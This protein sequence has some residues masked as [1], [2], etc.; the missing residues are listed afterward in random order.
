MLPE[1]KRSEVV[2][3]FPAILSCDRSLEYRVTPTSIPAPA[4]PLFY[5]YSLYFSEQIFISARCKANIRGENV[6]S[7]MPHK[8]NDADEQILQQLAEGGNLP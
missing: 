4:Q 6:Q 8:L 3:H 2:E 5:Q 1:R 7:P